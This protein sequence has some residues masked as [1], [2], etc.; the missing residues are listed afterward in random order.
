LPKRVAPNLKH[1]KIRH[2]HLA[3]GGQPFLFEM[4]FNFE[5]MC[6]GVLK[7]V[8]QLFFTMLVMLD[9]Q[10]FFDAT[11]EVIVPLSRKDPKDL[12]FCL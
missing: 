2:R 10:V 6:I 1:R 12:H 5:P 3:A 11:L 7:G 8:G 4:Q 9:L